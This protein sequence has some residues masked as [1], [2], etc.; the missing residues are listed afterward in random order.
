MISVI[1][2][3]TAAM[4]FNEGDLEQILAT[5]RKNNSD[6]GITGQ[7]L[8]ADGNFI[9]AVEGPEEAVDKL[10]ARLAGDRRHRNVITIARYPIAERQ[11]PNWSMGFRRLRRPEIGD[12]VD[13]ASTITTPISDPDQPENSVARR[14]LDLF[15]QTNPM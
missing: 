9:Q 7:L 5:S 12:A 4:L 6:Q 2:V 11:F 14:L 8:Y 13:R 1:Y 10:L 3:S 15:R